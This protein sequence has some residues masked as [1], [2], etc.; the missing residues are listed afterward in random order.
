MKDYWSF[1]SVMRSFRATG[2]GSFV[3]SQDLEWRQRGKDFLLVE[4][5]TSTFKIP[6]GANPNRTRSLSFMRDRIGEEVPIKPAGGVWGIP[7]LEEYL[8]NLN[9]KTRYA[10]RLANRDGAELEEPSK[11][12]LRSVFGDWVETMEERKPKTML[13][14]GHYLQMIDDPGFQFI[15]CKVEGKLVGASGF[16]WEGKDGAVCFTKHVYTYWW[17]SR[18]LWYWSL[19]AL[20]AKGVETVNCG[21][22]ADKL[23]KELGFT[24]YRQYKVDFS[25]LEQESCTTPIAM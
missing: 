20:R 3:K 12:E 14:K 11:K 4:S 18:F 24:R 8:H 15:S 10:L 22:T 2:Y 5:P 25:K 17:L 23:K 1:E 9:R 7:D 13:V 21:D 16:T 6:A 19:A